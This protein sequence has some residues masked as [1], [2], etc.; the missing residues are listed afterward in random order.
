MFNIG[1][2]LFYMY[3]YVYTLMFHVVEKTNKFALPK[4]KGDFL[5][6]CFYSEVFPVLPGGLPA[7]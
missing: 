3:I 6:E 7:P 4:F 5:L 2:F 1:L